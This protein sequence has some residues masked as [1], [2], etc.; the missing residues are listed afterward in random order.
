MNKSKVIL[1]IKFEVQQNLSSLFYL[2]NFINL[3]FT[4]L[5]SIEIKTKLTGG[6]MLMK[7]FLI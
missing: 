1:Y 2:R 3:L 4:Y 5:F 7:N 6:Q